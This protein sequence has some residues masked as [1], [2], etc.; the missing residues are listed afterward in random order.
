MSLVIFTLHFATINTTLPDYP[1]EKRRKFTLHFAT[2]NT[3][4]DFT[5]VSSHLKFT[6]HF[7]TINTSTANSKASLNV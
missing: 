2:I 3:L 6:L 7:A 4:F 1:N 5:L